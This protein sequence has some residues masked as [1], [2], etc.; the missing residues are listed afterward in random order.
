MPEEGCTWLRDHPDA[1]GEAVRPVH[2]ETCETCRAQVEGLERM[3][4]RGLR[5]REVPVPP[6]LERRI[7]AAVD[8]RYGT[9]RRAPYRSWLLVAAALALA[10]GA[11]LVWRR[12]TADDSLAYG[13]KLPSQVAR[14]TAEPTSRSRAREIPTAHRAEPPDAGRES[15]PSWGCGS[16]A[17][18][19]PR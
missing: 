10:I 5:A 16:P 1:L 13:P 4:R 19:A 3:L 15:G 14:G 7:L 11:V 6:E 8:A 9:S 2:L 18:G 17:P 12:L